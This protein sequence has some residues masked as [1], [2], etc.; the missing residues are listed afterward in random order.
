TTPAIFDQN[1]VIQ[2]VNPN[3]YFQALSRVELFPHVEEN[4]TIESFVNRLELETDKSY[5]FIVNTIDCA[6]KLYEQLAEVVNEEEMTFLS[7]HI[8]SKERLRR[9]DE[10]KK[11]TYRFVVSTQ[12]VEAGVDIDFD[13]VYRDL[14]PLD[15]IHQAAGR[16]NRHGQR[17]GEVHVISL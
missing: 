16:C 2:L 14:A 1:K 3:D 9:I 4:V 5:L 10:I 15:S 13:I 12:L 7:T 8:P 17:K 6:K 11:G